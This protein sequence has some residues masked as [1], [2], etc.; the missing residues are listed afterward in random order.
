MFKSVGEGAEI[1]QYNEIK[2][3]RFAGKETT[4]TPPLTVQGKWK[5]QWTAEGVLGITLYELYE[6]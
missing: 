4:P 1:S 5:L 3:A 6:K 2:I